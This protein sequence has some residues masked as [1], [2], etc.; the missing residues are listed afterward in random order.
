[1]SDRD[2]PSSPVKALFLPLDSL[3]FAPIDYPIRECP[4]WRKATGGSGRKRTFP[5][6]GAQLAVRPLQRHAELRDPSTDPMAQRKTLKASLRVWV[7]ALNLA[8]ARR[9]P[10]AMCLVGRC[11]ARVG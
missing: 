7:R 3:R 2:V 9:R 4:V 10:A 8:N 11:A 5:F 6:S 1:V